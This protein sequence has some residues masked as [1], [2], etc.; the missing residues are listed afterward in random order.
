MDT[1]TVIFKINEDLKHKFKMKC[2][3]EKK[4]QQDK[5]IE[6]VKN[7]VGGKN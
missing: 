2:L 7:C 5:L 1:K 6:L 3:E 4:S